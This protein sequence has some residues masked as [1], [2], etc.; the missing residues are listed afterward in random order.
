MIS[1]EEVPQNKEGSKTNTK[2]T[3]K[4]TPIIKLE[5]INR[6]LKNIKIS[7]KNITI[8]YIPLI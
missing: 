7:K 8:K 2:L 5:F 4:L 6:N 1:I 3:N